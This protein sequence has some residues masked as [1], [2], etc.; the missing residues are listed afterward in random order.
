MSMCPCAPCAMCPMCPVDALCPCA[1][2]APC[3]LCPMGPCARCGRR[4]TLR[5]GARVHVVQRRGGP[6]GRACD[7]MRHVQ[8]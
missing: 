3:G 4:R 1:P 8:R 2:C 6:C 5:V 7:A